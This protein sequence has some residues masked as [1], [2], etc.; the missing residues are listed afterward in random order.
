MKRKPRTVLERRRRNSAR[1]ALYFSLALMGVLVLA[2]ARYLKTLEPTYESP[3][4][5]G[6]DFGQYP[7]VKLLQQYLRIDTS[8]PDADERLGAQFLA[9]QLEAAGIDAHVELLGERHANVWAIL[10]GDD[11][12]ALVLHNHIDTDPIP[13]P[14]LWRRDPHSGDLEG[15]WIYGR[16]AYDMKGTAIA[17][18]QAFIELHQSGLPLRRSVIFLATGSEEIGS[19]YGMRWIL[20]EHPELAGRFWGMVTEGGALENRSLT[21]LKYWGIEFAQKR[22]V[23]VI[24]CSES[25][26]RLELLRVELKE[27]DTSPPE[28]IR[29]DPSVAAY[30][31]Q[32][33][34][35]RD[36]PLLRELLADPY[37][38]ERSP[39]LVEIHD[40]PKVLHSAMHDEARAAIAVEE[41][42]GGFQL[43]VRFYLLPGSDF[44]QA[45]RR[46][47]PE[48]RTYG[49]QMVT[50]P[51][52][53]YGGVSPLDH[54]LYEELVA[55]LGAEYPDAPIGPYFLPW[56]ATDSRFVRSD[57]VVSYGLSPF[58]VP[59][60]ET[61]QI[62]Q[63]NERL[64]L[65]GFLNGI[66]VY[67]RL[68]FD[69][70][71]G[72]APRNL[73]IPPKREEEI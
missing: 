5:R 60:T 20:A 2:G 72:A 41:T 13:Y 6:I 64:N 34:P 12:R 37:Q 68:L 18:L 1:F 58:L 35:S 46:L 14:D 66:N 48:W 22:W 11:R 29:I 31:K 27:Q 42:D 36:K 61:L 19:D 56:T 39:G 4:W 44:E 69:L 8:Q 59:L 30:L 55:A 49:L 9:A 47:L 38:F 25:R 15:P 45:R 54:P 32:Y 26:E 17:Q 51:E 63:P 53:G 71:T 62:G 40:V 52:Q 43:Q 57:D 7:S 16:G 28:T 21:D 3:P 65:L 70:A 23:D 73:W 24:L 67:R 10:E 33:G 50:Y